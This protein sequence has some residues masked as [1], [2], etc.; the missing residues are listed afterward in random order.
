MRLEK[1]FKKLELLAKIYLTFFF[2]VSYKDGRW[3]KLGKSLMYMQKMTKKN[4]KVCFRKDGE[5]SKLL[6]WID[7]EQLLGWDC[8]E[9]IIYITTDYYPTWY[10]FSPG[11]MLSI[12][13]AVPPASR[14]EPNENRG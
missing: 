12:F 10:Q 1:D 9:C 2:R 11:F 3:N 13:F 14:M 8:F 7:C 4:D 6:I 5:S